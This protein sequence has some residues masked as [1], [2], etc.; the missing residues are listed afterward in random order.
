MPHH[1]DSRDSFY[2]FKELYDTGGEAA[3]A[4][5]SRSMPNLQ[6]RIEAATEQAVVDLAIAE[7]GWAQVRAANELKKQGIFISP[8]G[9]SPQ[10]RYDLLGEQI[11][12]LLIIRAE[13]GEG[14]MVV[15]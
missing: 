12:S 11:D 13:L 1:G 5:I 2:R 10:R 4:E 9:A 8:A 7:P 3:L 6:N 14:D 15:A